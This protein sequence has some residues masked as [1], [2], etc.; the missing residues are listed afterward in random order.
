LTA[1]LAGGPFRDYFQGDAGADRRLNWKFIEMHDTPRFASV[2]DASPERSLLAIAYLAF[3]EGVPVVYYGLEQGLNGRCDAR[4]FHLR[5]REDS[6]RLAQACRAGGSDGIYRQDMFI[7]GTVKLGSIVPEI[8]RLAGIGDLKSQKI[9]TGN[10]SRD[11]SLDPYLRRDH[12]VFQKTR[13][14]LH[15]RQS[16]APLRRGGTRVLWADPG[17]EGVLAFS[18]IDAQTSDEILVVMNVSP[19]IRAMPSDLKIQAPRPGRMWGDLLTGKRE[20]AV[21]ADDGLNFSGTTL[22]PFAVHLL[23]PRDSFRVDAETRI[24]SCAQ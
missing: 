6:M 24:T 22:T 9:P 1:F 23:A 13:Q 20:V 2:G 21:E 10:S 8:D 5:A 19:Q 4:M 16:C 3:A 18:R 14:F 11:S 15:L 12:L 7:D 17:T